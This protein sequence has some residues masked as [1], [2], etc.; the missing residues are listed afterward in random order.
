MG[1]FGGRGADIDNIKAGFGDMGGDGLP[2]SR[3]FHVVEGAGHW[4]QYE[5]PDLVNP[6]LLDVLAG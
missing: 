4:A 6:L 1:A 2:H 5:R 3:G